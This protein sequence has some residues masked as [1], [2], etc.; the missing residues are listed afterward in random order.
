MSRQI[1]VTVLFAIVTVSGCGSITVNDSGITI[2]GGDTGVVTSEFCDSTLTT[3]SDATTCL[4]EELSCGDTVTGTT[5]GG[6]NTWSGD[7]YTS[8]FCFVDSS[9]WDGGERMYSF[10]QPADSEV[11]IRF[12]HCNKAAMSVVSWSDTGSCPVDGVI[13]RCEGTS[14]GSSVH[15]STDNELRWVI[16]IDTPDGQGG[17]Y[18]LT[19][20]CG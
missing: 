2:G 6:T 20:D 17:N 14:T 13:N 15:L 10:T 4:T 11:E 16:G 5:E 7:F 19:V 8:N 3:S 18:T 9:D 12:D 1:A